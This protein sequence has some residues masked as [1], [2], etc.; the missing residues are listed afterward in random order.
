MS[1]LLQLEIKLDNELRKLDIEADLSVTPDINKELTEQPT[2]FATYCALSE[3]AHKRL[4]EIDSDLDLTYSQLYKSITTD[5]KVDEDE[6]KPVKKE[7]LTE[8]A[9]KNMIIQKKAYQAILKQKIE[10]EYIYNILKGAKQAF[11]QR[12]QML[13]QI[14]SNSRKELENSVMTI[15][16]QM[17]DKIK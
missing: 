11:E 2:K 16:K 12:C 5:D 10:M 14:G 8:T 9:I 1:N 7:K 17:A 6:K 15:K 13:I 4:N 3:F